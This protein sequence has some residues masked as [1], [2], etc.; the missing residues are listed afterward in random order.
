MNY[1]KYREIRHT[2]TEEQINFLNVIVDIN[3][4]DSL[5]NPNT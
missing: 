5:E 1:L 4:L 3:L 2:L